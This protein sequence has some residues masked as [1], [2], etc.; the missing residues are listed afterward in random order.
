M[1]G[2]SRP[3]TSEQILSNEDIAHPK[4][5]M[6]DH[7]W[8]MG[9]EI[10]DWAMRLCTD[11][12]PFRPWFCLPT[13]YNVEE[14]VEVPEWALKTCDL[15]P[16]EPF[17][18]SNYQKEEAGD[19]LRLMPILNECGDTA[20]FH[21]SAACNKPG[22]KRDIEQIAQ[23]GVEKH[24]ASALMGEGPFICAPGV[25]GCQW[26]GAYG[27]RTQVRDTKDLPPSPG[28]APDAVSS[29]K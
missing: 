15:P 8:N 2:D 6:R 3:T 29:E 27:V 14:I 4:I 10:P 20:V 13:E 21:D 23:G 16:M 25:E 26:D 17:W 12:P 7:H 5:E 22:G 1:K 24:S 9:V 11:V 18:C 19:V 28:V